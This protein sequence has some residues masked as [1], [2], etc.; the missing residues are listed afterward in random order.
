MNNY[1][2]EEVNFFLVKYSLPRE[3][4]NLYK[5][6]DEEYRDLFTIQ[7]SGK[8]MF[9]SLQE[10]KNTAVYNKE[11]LN[12]VKNDAAFAM[13]LDYNNFVSVR[14]SIGVN[15]S[16]VGIGPHIDYISPTHITIDRS[17]KNKQEIYKEWVAVSKNGKEDFSNVFV[18]MRCNIFIIEP[19]EGQHAWVEDKVLEIP[20]GGYGAVFDSGKVHGTTPG[21]H[22]KMTLSL[23]YLVR[24]E[25][26][27]DLVK[28][29]HSLESNIY[30]DVRYMAGNY[31]D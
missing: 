11:L 28:K 24:K 14:D 12:N 26:F 1:T 19:Q 10:H 23:G 9:I 21:S 29:N 30:S 6:I 2:S 22:K 5:N 18:Q 27:R 7:P 3:L 4:I 16:E 13:G 17:N 25:V 15:L 20:R 8:R 31:Q